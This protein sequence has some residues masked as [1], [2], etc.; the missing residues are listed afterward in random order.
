MQRKIVEVLL[1]ED[2]LQDAQLI[3]QSL[4]DYYPGIAITAVEDGAGALDCLFGTGPYTNKGPFTPHL[5]LLDLSI[6]KVS[7]LELLRV[8]RAYARTRL[9]PVVILS[10]SPEEHKVLES[11]KLGVNSYLVK[12]REIEQF[13]QVVRQ[14]GAYWMNV[15][16]PQG[17]EDSI[18][19][20]GKN[21]PSSGDGDMTGP[22][23]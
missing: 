2:N 10:A 12:P 5:I 6:P 23:R 1:V 22:E 11:Y 14:I 4:K 15:S 18:S 8:I 3:I 17:T 9:I 16:M 19:T 21:G 13:R 7:G 20:N